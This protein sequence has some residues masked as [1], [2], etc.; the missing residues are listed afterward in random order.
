MAEVFAVYAV[1]GSVAG[2]TTEL[3][4]FGYGVFSAV[5]KFVCQRHAF[6][7]NVGSNGD[8]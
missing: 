7:L 4:D 8:I 3:G 6:I 2:E 5:E 1:E